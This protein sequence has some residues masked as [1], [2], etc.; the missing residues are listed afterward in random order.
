MPGT[1]NTSSDESVLPFRALTLDEIPD[2]DATDL[3]TSMAMFFPVNDRGEPD[4]R[5]SMGNTSIVK[6]MQIF[7][8]AMRTR[9]KP[10]ESIV[11]APTSIVMLF[12]IGADMWCLIIFIFT[13]APM[14]IH[15]SASL[16]SL[17]T[18]RQRPT[19]FRL[20]TFMQSP[21]NLYDIRSALNAVRT[22]APPSTD[23]VYIQ[24]PISPYTNIAPSAMM[25]IPAAGASNLT[26]ARAILLCGDDTPLCLFTALG[27][28]QLVTTLRA[29]QD[30]KYTDAI[31]SFIQWTDERG[32]FPHEH[33]VFAMN[34]PDIIMLLRGQSTAPV[35]V[36]DA[37]IA[38]AIA[39]S[40]GMLP[41]PYN[42]PEMIYHMILQHDMPYRRGGGTITCRFMPPAPRSAET[43]SMFPVWMN[44]MEFMTQFKVDVIADWTAF[45]PA[46]EAVYRRVMMRTLETPDWIVAAFAGLTKR[47][48]IPPVTSNPNDL[49]V[50]SSNIWW[51]VYGD[52]TG[53][54]PDASCRF[55]PVLQERARPLW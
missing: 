48:A 15:A 10:V 37:Y 1:A 49:M 41:T 14:A 2:F 51:L 30:P 45:G 8:L 33:H 3:V 34:I 17:L 52:V 40:G 44:R 23:Y 9:L 28:P 38:A 26:R 27:I 42:R 18:E 54:P 11:V 22:A 43:C 29:I 55:N 13:P 24:P 25:M 12:R 4:M 19:T 21:N 20:P 35:C 5:V 16:G 31:G 32:H 6:I 46:F 36:S 53:K 50:R 47:P 39:M 7:D